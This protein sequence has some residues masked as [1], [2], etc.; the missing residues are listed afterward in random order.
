[1]TF[2]VKET[3]I[4]LY[5]V[6]QY[7]VS[8]NVGFIILYNKIKSN[9]YPYIII[10]IMDT[11]IDF[12]LNPPFVHKG[13]NFPST[14]YNHRWFRN[15]II[16]YKNIDFGITV[17]P[18]SNNT[19]YN[20]YYV[21]KHICDNII[22][23]NASQYPNDVSEYDIFCKVYEHKKLNNP[24]DFNRNSN[25]LSYIINSGYYIKF[26]KK[27]FLCEYD[28]CH[29]KIQ[30]GHVI[31]L[32]KYLNSIFNIYTFRNTIKYYNKIYLL[33]WLMKYQRKI[34]NVLLKYKIMLFVYL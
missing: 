5:F 19:V 25:L 30:C 22:D 33:L 27:R 14:K 12:S 34:P 1:M 4:I 11:Y 16:N 13:N 6:G 29:L 20:D 2:C 31:K 18:Y 26:S 23:I 3:N 17:W 24:C 10:I 28:Y 7:V 8:F 32:Q 21:I 9:N 15:N